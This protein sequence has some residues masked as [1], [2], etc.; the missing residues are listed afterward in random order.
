MSG[1]YHSRNSE[2]KVISDLTAH[3][4][5]GFF[6]DIG[7]GD[8]RTWSNT[9]GLFN[10]KWKGIAIECDKIKFLNLSMTMTDKKRCTLLNQSATPYNVSEMISSA[11]REFEVLSLDIDGYDYFVLMALL[12]THRPK[13]IV[14]EIQPCVPPPYKFTVLFKPDYKWKEDGFFGQSIAAAHSLLTSHG[15]GLHSIIQDNAVFVFGGND[16][17]LQ[18][19]W[20]SQFVERPDGDVLA[21]A[22]GL[23]GHIQNKHTCDAIDFIK[24]IWPDRLNDYL[25]WV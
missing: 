7:A 15:Y 25:L 4:D 14:L 3:V 13:I 22:K 19:C 5:I 2:E 24:T 8:G 23:S 20:Q 10:R 1:Q 17:D 9:L 6:V 12:K 16:A 21:F 11:P 18:V